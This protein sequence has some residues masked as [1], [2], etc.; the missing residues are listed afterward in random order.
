MV[1]MD[2]G[3]SVRDVVEDHLRDFFKEKP[4]DGKTGWTVFRDFPMAFSPGKWLM[5]LEQNPDVVMSK[6]QLERERLFFRPSN[7]YSWAMEPAAKWMG[8]DLGLPRGATLSPP[9]PA[10][11]MPSMWYVD[12]GV[13]AHAPEFSAWVC[14]VLRHAKLPVIYN[15]SVRRVGKD[16]GLTA[17]TVAKQLKWMEKQGY[18]AQLPSTDG[19]GVHL[20]CGTDKDGVAGLVELLKSG[21]EKA[22]VPVG[23]ADVERELSLDRAKTALHEGEM[24]LAKLERDLE[25]GGPPNTKA[26]KEKAVLGV[27]IARKKEEV[28]ELERVGT[29]LG[30]GRR[31]GLAL[32][33]PERA[34]WFFALPSFSEVLLKSGHPVWNFSAKVREKKPMASY[35]MLPL[36]WMFYLMGGRTT[37]SRFSADT[38]TVESPVSVAGQEVAPVL[39]KVANRS[40]GSQEPESLVQGK[41]ADSEKAPGFLSKLAKGVLLLLARYATFSDGWVTHKSHAWFAKTLGLSEK[42]ANRVQA[43][44]SVLETVG[45]LRIVKSTVRGECDRYELFANNPTTWKARNRWV[46]M[47]QGVEVGKKVLRLSQWV[48]SGAK[49]LKD[50]M[51]K[52]LARSAGVATLHSQAVKGAAPTA[53]M[54]AT[55]D[56]IESAK[57]AECEKECVLEGQ[58][59]KGGT[60]SEYC[61]VPELGGCFEISGGNVGG[62]PPTCDG[63]WEARL[64][65]AATD[66]MGVSADDWEWGEPVLQRAPANEKG[67]SPVERSGPVQKEAKEISVEEST[68][69][70]PGAVVNATSVKKTAGRTGEKCGTK[71]Q[72]EV[73]IGGAKIAAVALTPEQSMKKRPKEIASTDLGE[74]KTTAATAGVSSRVLDTENG[75]A[76][77]RVRDRVA[78]GGNRRHDQEG[79]GIATSVPADSPRSAGNGNSSR[80]LKE[81][82]L[83]VPTGAVV[84]GVP[85]L[86]GG[87]PGMATAEG[88]DAHTQSDVFRSGL[89]GA[90]PK[91][92]VRWVLK[93]MQVRGMSWLS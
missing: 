3:K 75:E 18:I 84:G 1:V 42:S 39:G 86:H 83:E 4:L 55:V 12:G 76:G 62:V 58:T 59:Q 85:L 78:S 26:E 27:K 10:C 24:R 11:G 69:T 36:S 91:V 2:W 60:E 46:S 9:G 71:G 25:G 92:V 30:N 22:Y 74:N 35:V 8:A 15:F 77:T 50:G 16:L 54:Y 67:T 47:L 13:A 89:F 20:V 23:Y 65:D 90:G 48:K 7:G 79:K 93:K 87:V 68:P 5:G 41:G 19:V 73:V 43:E 44:L 57:T 56:L 51:G 82:Q 88:F 34:R 52:F 64:R 17:A 21:N 28:A 31:F 38:A 66:S 49:V 81:D 40:Q 70:A 61:A 6:E 63:A 14:V 80:K 33:A 45:L 32:D 37:G 72:V 29:V 53:E